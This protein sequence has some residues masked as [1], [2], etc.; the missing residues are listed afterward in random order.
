MTE[1]LW[2]LLIMRNVTEKSCREYQ[3][4]HVMFSNF[5]PKTVP[6]MRQCGKCGGATSENTI[7]RM[8]FVC[9]INK[10]RRAHA[11]ADAHATGTHTLESTHTQPRSDRC[12]MYC[13]STATVVSRTHLCVRWYVHCLSWSNHELALGSA[14]MR[15]FSVQQC[16]THEDRQVQILLCNSL[17]Q[18]SHC[19]RVITPSRSLKES[20]TNK[21]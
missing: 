16:A 13:F 18:K 17:A 4:I 14:G 10:A 2:I 19:V 11:H 1:F 9:W 3:N 20:E 15:Q 5:F 6:F 8:R 21:V 7:S 12:N